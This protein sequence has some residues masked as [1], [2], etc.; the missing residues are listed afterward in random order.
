M[1]CFYLFHCT[2]IHFFAF[3]FL[4]GYQK[5]HYVPILHWSSIDVHPNVSVSFFKSN[6]DILFWRWFFFWTSFGNQ[7]FFDHLIFWSSSQALKKFGYHLNKI[8][9]LCLENFQ[10]PPIKFQLSNWCELIST[11]DLTIEK[12]WS[13]FEKKLV[14]FQK[15]FGRHLKFFWLFDRQWLNLHHWSNDQIWATFFF[16]NHYWTLT[17]KC[18]FGYHKV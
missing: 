4:Q 10:L 9:N 13:P 14:V 7:F 3:M 1:S 8:F 16:Y 5:W 11:I 12:N 6:I 17:I 15:K 2:F 18:H